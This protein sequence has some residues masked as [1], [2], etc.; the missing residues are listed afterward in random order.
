MRLSIQLAVTWYSGRVGGPVNGYT[1]TAGERIGGGGE[2]YGR[3]WGGC[4]W[5]GVVRVGEGEKR[6]DWLSASRD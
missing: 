1:G 2:W 4:G 6:R 5:E 3:V